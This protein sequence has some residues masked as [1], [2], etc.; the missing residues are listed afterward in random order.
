MRPC[1]QHEGIRYA[2]L[3]QLSALLGPVQRSV[4]T[5]HNVDGLFF[6]SVT[7]FKLQKPPLMSNNRK[8]PR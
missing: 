8:R 6:D 1:F 2:R 4:I 7:D 3:R 5:T